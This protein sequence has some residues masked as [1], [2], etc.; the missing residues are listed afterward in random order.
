MSR[1]R[2]LPQ[3]MRHNR[4]TSSATVEAQLCLSSSGQGAAVQFQ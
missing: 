1:R 2:E 4:Q 3:Y